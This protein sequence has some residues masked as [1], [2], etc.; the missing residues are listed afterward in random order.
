MNFSFPLPPFRLYNTISRKLESIKPINPPHVT[1][2]ACG[3]TVYNLA[4]I[5]NFRT[6]LCVDLL[7]RALEL[8]GYKVIH[9][10]N[11]TDIDDK[12]IAASR[13]AGL[14]LVEYTQKYI[15]AFEQDMQ[16]LHLLK[17]H[18]QPKATEHIEK[19]IEFIRQLIDKNH[20]YIGEDGSVY[21]RIASFPDYGKLSHLEKDKLKPGSHILADE[22]IK[23]H[24][25]DFALWKAKK[26]EDG[27]VGWISPWEI[28]R[29]GWHIECST[30]SICYLGNEIDIHCGGVDLIFPHH[31]NEIAQSESVTG[32]NFVRHWFHVAHVLVEGEKMSK[33]LGNIY[34]IR[35]ILERGFNERTLRY[36][37]LTAS[38]YRQTLNFTWQGMEA[39]REAVK[40]IDQW[41]SRFQS[42]PKSQFQ[43][44]EYEEETRFLRCFVE[45]LADDL[46]ITEAIGHLFDWI[47]HTNRMMDKG[48]PLPP[49]QRS[50]QLV[51][52]ILGIGEF[53]VEIP[54]EIQTLLQMRAEARKNKNW[55]TSDRIRQQLQ[56]MGWIVQDTPEGQKAWKV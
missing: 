19:M 56:E 14:S 8:F 54:P 20:A 41:L 2:Y 11:Y 48:E 44:Q 29:P 36:H 39:S 47:R 53:S 6:F 21:F 15:D 33:S 16:T 38:H 18:F 50:W 10:M 46:N 49:L 30:M 31:E 1:M 35:D 22:Y 28:G 51:D 13:A 7:R 9:T 45:A 32:Q 4:H 3:P 12:T 34:T 55:A 25:G 43:L 52:T 37:L 24:Y 27:E 23:E 17:P 5:G 42:L 40:R 26:P